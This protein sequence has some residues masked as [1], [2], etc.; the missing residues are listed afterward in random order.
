M[1]RA[2][3][4][5]RRLADVEIDAAGG[6]PQARANLS[7]ATEVTPHAQLQPGRLDARFGYAQIAFIEIQNG[8]LETQLRLDEIL[9]GAPERLVQ[10]DP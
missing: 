10:V 7:P 9:S 4:H 1:E 8:R 2:F 5:E 3:G 6:S